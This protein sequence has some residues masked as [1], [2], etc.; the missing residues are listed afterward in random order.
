[1]HTKRRPI[2]N[3]DHEALPSLPNYIPAMLYRPQFPNDV[4]FQ[5]YAS[6]YTD[7]FLSRPTRTKVLPSGELLS[8]TEYEEI[9]FI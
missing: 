4:L 1:M 8:L 6:A 9:F 2:Y 3:I 5:V 7:I